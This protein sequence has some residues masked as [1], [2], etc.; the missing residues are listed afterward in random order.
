MAKNR[1]EDAKKSLEKINRSTPNY[2]VAPDL[3]AIE[4]Q[5]NLDREL[6]AESSWSSL[7]FDPV[8]RRKLIYACGVMFAQQINGI[9]FWYTYGVVFAQSIGV[10]E[11]FTI[12]T[13]IYVSAELPDLIT[14]ATDEDP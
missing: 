9:Q 12:N 2:N 3:Q 11:P 10:G 14:S 7:F 5:I 6:E 1:K 13:I 4:D 8:E